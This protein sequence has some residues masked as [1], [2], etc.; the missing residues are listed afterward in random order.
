MT[1]FT[2]YFYDELFLSQSYVSDILIAINPYKPMDELY[3][4]DTMKKYQGVLINVLPAHVF[5]TG[6]RC[7]R[8]RIA[9]GS[10][11][12]NGT[13]ATDADISQII[14]GHHR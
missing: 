10:F 6:K 1:Q 12:R 2:F 7:H 13:V 9:T 5:G 11:F 3:T 4:F 14:S 8:P